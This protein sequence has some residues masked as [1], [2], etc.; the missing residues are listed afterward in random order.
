[1]F[2]E[3]WLMECR[4]PTVGKLCFV[5]YNKITKV[6]GYDTFHPGYQIWSRFKGKKTYWLTHWNLELH[7]AIEGFVYMERYGARAKGIRKWT[8]GIPTPEISATEEVALAILRGDPSAVDLA[9]DVLS[10]GN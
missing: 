6:I 2:R 10:R 4:R 9:N 5:I 7:E 8:G 1:M 3:I